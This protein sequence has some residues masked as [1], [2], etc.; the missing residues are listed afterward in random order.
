M[1]ITE[2]TTLIR[3]FQSP[4]WINLGHKKNPICGSIEPHEIDF[5]RKEDFHHQR[6]EK[7]EILKRQKIMVVTALYY[8]LFQSLLTP[9]HP[10][11]TMPILLL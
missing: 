5:P 4:V 10:K 9:E 6:K 3:A 11:N 8:S 1:I 2:L 7:E